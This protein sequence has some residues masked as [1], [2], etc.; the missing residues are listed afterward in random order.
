MRIKLL[1]ITMLVFTILIFGGNHYAARN[2]VQSESECRKCDC[3]IQVVSVMGPERV[4]EPSC[5]VWL[6]K[7]RGS[8]SLKYVGRWTYVTRDATDCDFTVFCDRTHVAK[9][10]CVGWD[11][12]GPVDPGRE[13]SY[14]CDRNGVPTWNC[15]HWERA[16]KKPDKKKKKSESLELMSAVSSPRFA[17][18]NVNPSFLSRTLFINWTQEATDEEVKETITGSTQWRPIEGEAGIEKGV[19]LVATGEAQA[20]SFCT[21]D[22]IRLVGPNVLSLPTCQIDVSGRW[23]G[24]YARPASKGTREA[25]AV[26]LNLRK[27]S[28]SL[29]G[30]IKTPDGTFNIV[31]GSQSGSD[32]RLRAERTGAGAQGKII[33]NGRLTKGDIVFDGSEQSSGGPVVYGLTGFVRRLHIA[34]NALPIVV[35]NQP[36]SFTLTAFAP[37]SQPITFRLANPAAKQPEQITWTT[38]AD[39]LRGRNGERFTYLCPANGTLNRSLY[40]GN[41][42]TDDS[43]ICTAAVNSHVINQQAGGVVTIQI[44]PGPSPGTGR[45]VFVSGEPQGGERGR[46]P[47]GLSFDSQSGTF[48]GTPT[49]LGSFDIS[50]VAD[51]GAG[52]VFEQPLTLVVKKLVVTN[53]LLP[54]GFVGQPYAAT[55]KVAGGQPPYRFSGTPPQGLQLDPITGALSGRPSSPGS[56]SSFEVTVRD[57]QNISESQKLRLSVRGTTILNSYFLPDASVGVP[58][59]MQFQAVGNVTP[60][61]WVFGRTDVSSIGLTL[62]EKTGELSGAPTKGGEFFIEVRAE[63]G[64]GVSARNFA[65]TIKQGEPRR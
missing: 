47:K 7:S 38:A 50:V 23:Q 21:G 45:F 30:E 52:N 8:V 29:R 53:G 40:R 41:A 22:T 27:E 3:T 20:R 15:P 10:H 6:S 61:N 34:D 17:S 51:D 59:R 5:S 36:Y 33:L 37:E 43:S 12:Q 35:L 19:L 11:G 62:N 58:Y 31:E 32:I 49:E 24:A 56:S 4:K 9:V 65:L 60:I 2:K 64:S 63:A 13:C 55:L 16:E 42:Y 46:L 57:S 44:Q 18:S 26:S 1:C 54:D 14:H 48:S 25:V 39:S 28:D